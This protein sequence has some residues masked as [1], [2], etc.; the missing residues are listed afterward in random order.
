MTDSTVEFSSSDTDKNTNITRWIFGISIVAFIWVVVTRFTQIEELMKTVAQGRLE[1]I[2][3]ALL[4]EVI[5][6]VVL[7]ATY[8]SAFSTVGVQ[9]RL[10]DL[11][12]ITL[13]SQFVN[14]VTPSAGASGAALFVDDAARRGQTPARTTAGLF[15]QSASVYF[16]I[17]IILGVGLAYLYIQHDLAPY[18]VAA[19]IAFLLITLA[20]GGVLMLGHWRPDLL[21][22]LLAWVQKAGNGL[23]SKFH[24]APFFSENWADQNTADLSQASEAIYSDRK[25]QAQTVGLSLATQILNLACLFAIFMAFYGPISFGPLVAGYAMGILFSIITITPQGI[26]A[27]EGI[28]A[29]VYE[30]FGIPKDVAVIVPLV[31]RGLTFWLPL[32]L[33]FISLRRVKSFGIGEPSLPKDWDVHLIALFTGLVGILNVL[34]AITPARADRQ[35]ISDRFLPLTVQY[36]G[37][38][39]AVLSGFAL[40]ILANS[41]ARRKRTAW[42]LALVVLLI[43]IISH[44]VEG[45][46]FEV[47]LLAVGLALWLLAMRDRYQARS[48]PSSVRQGVRALFAGALF[49]LVYGV[50]G[51]YLLDRHYS[52]NFNLWDAVRQTIV[53]YTRFYDPGLQPVTGFGRYF[54]I[55]IYVVGAFTLFFAL[56]MLIRPVIIRQPA[57]GE[58]RERARR[59]VE[60]YGRSS[61]ARYTLLEDKSYFFSSGGSIVAYAQKEQAA[62]GLGDPIG[63]AEDVSSVI[64]EFK[65]YCAKNDWQPAFY[66]VLPDNLEQYRGAG[67]DVV[68]IGQEAIIDLRNFTLEGKSAKDIRSPYNRLTRLGY[69][70]KVYEPPLADSL[71]A[72]LRSISDEWLKMMHGSEKRFSLGWFDD[73]YIRDSRVIAVHTPAGPVSAFA[74]INPEYQ[75][76]EATI[77]LMRHRE[78]A[79]NGTMD[80]LFVSLFFWAKSKGYDTFNLGLSG[81]SGV[82]ETPDDPALERALHYVYEHVNQFY[83][84]KGLHK[85]KEKFNPNW[86]PRYLIYPGAGSLLPVAVALVEADSGGK[87]IP[88]SPAIP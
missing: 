80:F 7:A 72:E 38:L 28:M 26:G 68:G 34:S 35:A 16:A 44:L 19:A 17:T 31:F 62:V 77:D 25:G 11:I 78:D 60:A 23:A 87:P 47:S 67:L 39:T 27:V 71:L 54:A 76:N 5:N 85:Y 30:S 53:M 69:Q 12:P 70:A 6:Y 82:G 48:D 36:G 13:A 45:L 21:H 32:V 20:Q 42:L 88:D 2:L 79:E 9:S 73:D 43:S 22:R 41:L 49:T 65:Q 40:L 83:N 74:N 3:A 14:V 75:K 81:L 10:L 15:L 51:F 64:A 84:F 57:T 33:G 59:I 61:L 8:Q 24:R 52:V 56:L 66:Q 50:T 29:L 58:E 55:S 46:Y 18:E 1:W 37:R 63:P 4:I 86:S